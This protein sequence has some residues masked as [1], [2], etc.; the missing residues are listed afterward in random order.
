MG[1]IIGGYLTQGLSW[2]WLFY[3]TTIV[4]AAIILLSV[5]TIRETHNPTIL[6][7]RALRLRKSSANP[8]FHTAS[9]KDASSAPASAPEAAPTRLS[10]ALRR[11]LTRPFR[12]LATHPAIQVISLVYAFNFGILFFVLSTFADLWV[13]GYGQSVASSGLHYAAWVVGELLGAGLAAPVLDRVWAALK[14][15]RAGDGG[16]VPEYRVPLMLPG[17]LLVP[18]GLFAYGWA[19][20]ARAF[21]LVPDVCAAV[22][23]AGT[24]SSTMAVH[25]YLIDA[26]PDHTASANAAASFLSSLFGFLFPLFAPQMY[27]TL[28][29]GWGNS[30]LGFIAIAVGFSGVWILWTYGARMRAKAKSTE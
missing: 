15:R 23:G 2:R 13:V 26:Y 29:Y 27:K 10:G 4:Q 6:S 9:E 3:I 30:L 25:S 21:W 14:Q 24:M 22:L 20:Q 17:A 1:P 11:S 12:L 28:G 18:A 16:A 5:F 19:A 7:R 8:H